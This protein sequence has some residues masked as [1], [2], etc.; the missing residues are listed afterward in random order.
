V[1]TTPPHPTNGTKAQRQLADTVELLDRMLTQ[2]PTLWGAVVDALGGQPGAQD[3]QQDRT[4]GHT[5]VTDEHGT[6]MPARTDPTGE[7][8]TRHDP[9]THSLRQIRRDATTI[10]SAVERIIREFE[11]YAARPAN[12]YERAQ[13]REAGRNDD[14]GCS[15]CA[16]LE[17][18]Q[19]IARWEPVDCSVRLGDELV[20]VCRWCRSWVKDTGVLPDRRVLQDHHDGKRVRRPA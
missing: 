10:A 2:W 4:S 13:T 5:T 8:A 12:A 9:A 14:P 6:P 11:R 17:V 15:S 3:T 1:T 18:S 19:G 16:R 20:P 7:A